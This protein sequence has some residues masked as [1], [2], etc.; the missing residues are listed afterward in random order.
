MTKEIGSFNNASG[1]FVNATS[2]PPSGRYPVTDPSAIDTTELA[3]V[4]GW[5]IIQAFYA[6]LPQLAPSVNGNVFNLW[7]ESYGGHY[8]YAMID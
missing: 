4:A 2:A 8:G 3:A 1:A 5:E 7:T 6:N